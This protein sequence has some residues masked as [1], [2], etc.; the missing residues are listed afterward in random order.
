MYRYLNLTH[1]LVYSE[2]VFG[3]DDLDTEELLTSGLLLESEK[4]SFE[5]R[6]SGWRA[7]GLGSR[8]DPHNVVRYSSTE[9]T[10][11]ATLT[12]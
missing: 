10:R 9:M 4:K 2:L 8:G 5:G 11:Y 6:S 1:W 3:R 7:N 12:K